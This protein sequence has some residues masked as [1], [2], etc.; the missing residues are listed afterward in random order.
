M[1]SDFWAG[2]TVRPN[3]FKPVNSAAMSC[4]LLLSAFLLG[5]FFVLFPNLASAEDTLPLTISSNGKDYTISEFILGTGD[6][7]GTTI[8]IN[9]SGFEGLPLRDGKLIVPV[10][11][12][13][14][15]GGEK[16]GWENASVG[17]NAITFMFSSSKKPEVVSFFAEDNHEKQYEFKCP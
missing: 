13:Y 7:G 17:N 10:W 11:C 14:T 9:G 4:R 6:D 2:R 8:T 16:Y 12:E 5:L 1:K 3:D 15:S